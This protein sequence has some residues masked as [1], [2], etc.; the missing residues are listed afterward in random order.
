M[1]KYQ[2]IYADPPW[3]YN[4]VGVYQETF[5]KRK[6]IRPL[7]DLPYSSMSKKAIKELP[8]D[9]IADNDCACFMWCNDSHLEDGIEIMKSWGF[10]YK[11]IAFVWVKKT[12]NNKLYANTG[13]WTMKN[14]E[15]CLFGTKGA[16]TKHKKAN[17]I[18]QV[19]EH[20]RECHSKKPQIFRDKITQL[21]GDELPKIE[22]FARQKTEGWDVWGNEVESSV[23]L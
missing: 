7:R 10:K 2:I 12:K 23:A 21:F 22:L 19:I 20:D 8:I 15:F 6:Q 16:M 4:D 9:D 1:K 17:N 14:A 13:S 18:Y 3:L 5:P 11:V